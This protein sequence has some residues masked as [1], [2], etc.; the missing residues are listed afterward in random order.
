MPYAMCKRMTPQYCGVNDL[1]IVEIVESLTPQYCGVNHL[2]IV[3]IV[4]SDKMLCSP[5][6]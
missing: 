6:S 2:D 3:E 5:K 1:D 4:E